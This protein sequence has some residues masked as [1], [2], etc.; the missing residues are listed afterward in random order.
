[1]AVLQINGLSKSYGDKIAL[2]RASLCLTP[3][4]YGLLGPNGAGKSTLMNMIAGN[5]AP[6]AGEILYNGEHTS[7]LGRSFRSV[8]G[9]MPQQQG[10]YEQFT[11][12]QFLSYMAGLKGLPKKRAKEEI[13]T[14]LGLVNLE[15]QSEKK[16]GAYSGGMK[17]RI[18]IAQ[19]LLGNPKILILDEPTAGLDPRERIRIRNIISEIALDKIVIFATHVVSDVEQIAKEIV[20]IKKGN[21]LGVGSVG[22]FFSELSGKVFEITVEPGRLKEVEREFL[23]RNVSVYDGNMTVR[24]ISEDRPRL[25]AAL[26]VRPTL[27]DVYL[28]WFA[29]EVGE[30]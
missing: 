1:M 11:G 23:V 30:E 13:E 5:L 16:L 17:Q 4:V 10:L 3:G 19:A 6:D 25:Y 9:Y 29:D 2:N 14:V 24:V 21:I 26:E 12:Y 20:L 7:A 18:L 27:E 28:Y 22:S 8:L 15:E